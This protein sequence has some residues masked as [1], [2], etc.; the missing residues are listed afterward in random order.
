[1]L[2]KYIP[3]HH[4]QQQQQQLGVLLDLTAIAAGKKGGYCCRRP[5]PILRPWDVSLEV[6]QALK[7]T[8][9]GR[10]KKGLTKVP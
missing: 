7:V 10:A 3:H 4:Q 5:I 1:M 2:K 8:Y 6:T 9:L